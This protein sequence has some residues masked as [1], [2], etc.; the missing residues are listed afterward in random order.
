METE[1]YTYH[2]IQNGEAQG[3]SFKVADNKNT[4]QFKAI[5]FFIVTIVFAVLGITLV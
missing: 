1:K 3:F 2:H 5:I 4:N